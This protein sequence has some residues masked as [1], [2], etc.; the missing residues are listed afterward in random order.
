M[1]QH[2]ARLFE[3]GRFSLPPDEGRMAIFVF[4][5]PDY[6]PG[7]TIVEDSLDA[8]D[9]EARRIQRY[10]RF[11]GKRSEYTKEASI[12]DLWD[13]LD[14][15]TVSD[16]TVIGISTL[17]RIHLT[18]WTRES[19]SAKRNGTMTYYEAI[20]RGGGWPDFKHLK[21]GSFYQRTS[22]NMDKAP[23][24]VPLGWGIMADRASIWAIPQYGFYPSTRHFR[25]RD[26]LI[27]VS[28]H[29]GLD[30]AETTGPM[31]YART[32]EIFGLR[33]TIALRG[34]PMPRFLYPAYDRLRNNE[35]LFRLHQRIRGHGEFDS[36]E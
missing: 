2:R 18:P 23:L 35:A 25:P 4:F 20:S 24:N 27:R 7:N 17:S 11:R 14:D 28:R 13:A 30:E 15:E 29:F 22:G 12:Y 1:E 8:M 36:P 31:D 32:K 19:R 21:Q 6:R 3:E 33:E 16:I 5:D 10:L 34:Y 26:G 9:R